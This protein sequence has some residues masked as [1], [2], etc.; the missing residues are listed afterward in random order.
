LTPDLVELSPP[1]VGLVVLATDH[2]IEHEIGTLLSSSSVVVNVTRVR[3]EPT[4][5]WS[6]LSSIAS[7]LEGALELLLPA[8]SVNCI[9]YGCTSGTIAAG[10]EMILQHLRQA[11]PG[12]A[13][14]TPVTASRSALKS[15]GC[16]RIGVLTPYPRDVHDNV[17][18]HIRASGFD[19]PV[20]ASF[21]VAEDKAISMISLASVREGVV[22]LSKAESLDGIFVSCTALGVVD[23]IQPLEKEIGLPIVTSNQALAWHFLRLCRLRSSVAGFGRLLGS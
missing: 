18:R 1:R 9:A 23:L 13:A 21:G 2:R 20:S 15:L 12:A 3:S 8:S 19:V 7:H 14:T 16:S 11:R 17:V 5:D 10:E 4:Y 6:S 22:S